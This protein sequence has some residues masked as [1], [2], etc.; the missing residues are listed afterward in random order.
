MNTMRILARKID[1]IK[2][3]Q[4]ELKDIVINKQKYTRSN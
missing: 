4:S 3:N 1:E 2:K